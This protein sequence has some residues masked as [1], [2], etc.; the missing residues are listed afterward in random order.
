MTKPKNRTFSTRVSTDCYNLIK[1]Y[2][3]KGVEARPLTET[4]VAV[5]SKLF[6]QWRRK[7]T[8]SGQSKDFATDFSE[9]S[10]QFKS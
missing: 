9:F 7:Q 6:A 4:A 2:I 8:E 5:I 10:E 1:H 3:E